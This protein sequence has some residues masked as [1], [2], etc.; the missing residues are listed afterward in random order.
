MP[1][2]PAPREVKVGKFQ[3]EAEAILRGCAV[4]TPLCRAMFD[5]RGGACALGALRVG[6]GERTTK[7]NMLRATGEKEQEMRVLYWRTYG[8]TVERDNDTNGLTR[9][10]I[11]ARIAA[12]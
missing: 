11:A 5:G 10:Q 8:V 1:F 3:R 9:E 2:D 12:L 6:N 7:G 4:T